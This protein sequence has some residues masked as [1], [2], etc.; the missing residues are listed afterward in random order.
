VTLF[1]SRDAGETGQA[2]YL[3]YDINT[4]KLHNKEDWDKGNVEGY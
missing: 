2:G 3:F 1:K 4:A